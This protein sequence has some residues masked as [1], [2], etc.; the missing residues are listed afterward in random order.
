[1]A[2]GVKIL[3]DVEIVLERS[4]GVFPDAEEVNLLSSR[5]SSPIFVIGSVWGTDFQCLR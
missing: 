4:V 5:L 2:A 3:G 1:L